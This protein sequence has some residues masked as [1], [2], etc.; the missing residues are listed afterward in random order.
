MILL[1]FLA[2][3]ILEVKKESVANLLI[4][5]I[6]PV[7]VF[8]GVVTTTL[9]AGALSLPILFFVVGSLIAFLFYAIG[10]KFWQ[11]GTNHILAFAS[12]S[13]NTGYFGLPVVLALFGQQT[14]GLAVLMILGI[15]LFENTVGFYLTVRAHSSPLEALKKLFHLPAVYAFIIAVVVNVVHVPLSPSYMDFAASFKGAY[16]VLGMMLVGLGL[17]GITEL[18]IDKAFVTLSFIAKFAVWPLLMGLIIL[19]DKHFFHLYNGQT[20]QLLIIMSAVP[21]AANTVAYASAFGVHPQKAAVAVFLSTL[22]ALVYIPLIGYL[23]I[24]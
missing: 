5:F 24:K 21:L 19:L 20:Y 22:F 14:L 10:K 12:G 3:K 6:A 4:Y 23:V 7:V 2:G 9:S 18:A 13:G 1:G 8:H 17:A 16:T 11:D 15:I